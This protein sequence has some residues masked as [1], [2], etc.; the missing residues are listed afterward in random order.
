[1]Q[2]CMGG[3][4]CG[5]YEEG[6]ISS[7]SPDT[8]ITVPHNEANNVIKSTWVFK[9]KCF[10]DGTLSKFKSRLCVIGDLQKKASITLRYMRKHL[11]K[12]N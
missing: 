2:Q 7:T 5:Y 9:L 3:I 1:M 4:I 12:L 11:Y 8:W 10:P 6:D